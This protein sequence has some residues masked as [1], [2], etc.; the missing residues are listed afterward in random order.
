[1]CCSTSLLV[2]RNQIV[3]AQIF[4]FP[5]VSMSPSLCLCLSLS[6]SE[7]ASQVMN[8]QHRLTT[9]Y[10][11]E[12]PQGSGSSWVGGLQVSDEGHR[13]V[14]WDV[15]T[16]IAKRSPLGARVAETHR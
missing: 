1:M 8:A 5:S 9:M 12:S 11:P 15:M 14:V 16:Y 10:P 7:F 4:L 6:L 2:D 3:L 13:W